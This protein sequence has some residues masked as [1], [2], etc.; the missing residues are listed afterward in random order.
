M[1][2]AGVSFLHT[3]TIDGTDVAGIVLA[4]ATIEH[5][6]R[7]DNE[8]PSPGNAYFTLVS[9]DAVPNIADQYPGFTWGDRI[10]S[11]FVSAWDDHYEGGLPRINVNAPITVDATTPTGFQP[12]WVDDYGTGFDSRRFTGV[13]TALD[14]APATIAV[15]AVTQ[16][17]WLTRVDIDPSG[18]PQE[19]ETARVARIAAAAGI[20]VTVDG[21]SS[22]TVAA[23]RA[24][25]E[26]I[27]TAW[28]LLGAVATSCD[29]VLYTTRAGAV[30]YRT[31]LHPTPAAI[32][33]NPAATLLDGLVMTMELGRVRNQVTVEYGPP[34]A[35]AT[36]TVSDA[37]SV[38]AYGVR[39]VTVSTSLAL[40]DDATAYANRMLAAYAA[41]DWVMESVSVNLRL[42]EWVDTFPSYLQALLDIDLD[43]TLT[44][45]DL[46]PASPEPSYTARVL[47]YREVLDPY[48]WT[49]TLALTP[50]GYGR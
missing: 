14:V 48:A 9:A 24:T 15:T 3:V 23:M 37:A 34:D 36:V 31:R 18:W 45:P 42:A 5:G 13:I 32:D 17:E 2:T 12:A 25:G 35:R 30:T 20:T 4:G 41:P 6:S 40:A 39:D 27:Q 1:P 16:A 19:S 11:G 44:L 8:T 38:A 21:A 47:G 7:R 28:A 46:L 33:V 49:L 29:G 10:P 22:A 43:N 50:A 26:A